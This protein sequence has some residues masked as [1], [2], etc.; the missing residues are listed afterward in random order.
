MGLKALYSF[1]TFLKPFFSQD[2]AAKLIRETVSKQ[3]QVVLVNILSSIT[4]SLTE[5][6]TLGLV[7]LAVEVMSSQSSTIIWSKVP[8]LGSFTGLAYWLTNIPSSSLFLFL[9]SSALFVQLLQ[10]ISRFINLVS[11]SYLSASIRTLVTSRIHA[12]ILN[13][14]F[15]CASNYKIGDLCDYAGSGPDAIRIQIEQTSNLVVLIP[16]CLTYIAVLLFLSPWMLLAVLIIGFT[17]YLLQMTMLPRIRKG[18][19][20]VTS[21]SVSV[22]ERITEDFQGLRLL[23]TSGQVYSAVEQL[24]SRLSGF[25]YQMRK[26]APRLALLGPVS[27]FLPILAITIIAGL[28][29]FIFGNRA[30]GVLPSLVTFVL[31]LQRLTM[32]ISMIGSVTNAFADNSGK[33]KRLN[34]ILSPTDKEFRRSGGHQFSL[35]KNA[36]VFNS[37]TLIYREESVPA[38]NNI[39]FSMK[40]GQTVALVG[41]SGAGK[42]SIAD[43]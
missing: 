40:K 20:D 6:A 42:S 37:V 2:P 23:H 25:E 32:R 11:V 33:L 27:T 41:P 12:Q 9:L 30:G 21:E 10:G 4:E 19:Q 18:S 8:F 22:S 39:S 7:F 24:F 13:L 1:K 34:Y 38:L 35:I 16:Q 43:V 15:S 14:S 3:W 26:Q 31:A 29:V 17:I 36:V 5:G 28:S